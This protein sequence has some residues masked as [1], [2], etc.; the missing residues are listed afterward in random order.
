MRTLNPVKHE[1]KRQEILNA[2]RR[3]FARDG[4]RGASISSICT[5][6]GI[7]S[8]HLYHYFASK[9]AILGAIA[10]MVLEAATEQFG[11]TVES[12][13]ALATLISDAQQAKLREDQGGHI[14]VLD[15]LAEAGRNPALAKVLQDH[16]RGMQQL[17]ADFLR[18]GQAQGR[19]DPS[20]D[21]RMAAAVLI[22]VIDGSKVMAVRDPSL[23]RTKA[24]ELLRTLIA[25]FLTPPEAGMMRKGAIG[26]VDSSPA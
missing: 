26:S 4:L 23:D 12:P 7:S 8:G 3:C 11:R 19:I 14:L 9:E 2:A 6:A 1:E 22:G 18:E 21:A 20:F 24:I 10:H 15:M 13:D 16:S 5:E 25:R 17:L